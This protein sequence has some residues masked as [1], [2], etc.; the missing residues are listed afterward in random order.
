[1]RMFWVRTLRQ[2]GSDVRSPSLSVFRAPCVDYARGDGESIGPSQARS[3]RPM[4]L[5]P[6]PLWVGQYGGL[7][8][9]Y[10]RDPAAGENAPAGPMYSRDGS[11]RRA[12][13]DPIGWA[14]LHKVPTP[15]AQL[16]VLQRRILALQARD[17]ELGADI[18][19]RD[20]ELQ[21]LGVELAALRECPHLA[22]RPAALQRRL[23]AL[24]A[25][26]AALRAERAETD[27]VVGALAAR[28]ARL[29]DSSVESGVP[30][31]ERRAHL[32]RWA[33]PADSTDI[34]LGA[35]LEVWGAISISLVI[36]CVVGLIVGARE[37]L[38]LGLLA[39]L[40]TVLV[41]E[42]VFHRHLTRLVTGV[43]VALAVVSVLVLM[44][45][46]FWQIVV[47]AVLAAGLYL[48]WDNL[49][50]LRG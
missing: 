18:A 39:L 16:A 9:L 42:A 28:Y 19:K 22:P 3:W 38:W 1:M 6:L 48:L 29:S 4:L 12:W 5:D 31:D 23:E 33:Q 43:T 30:A 34:R 27:G 44:Y 36:I 50:E 7:W 45:T 11:V 24:Q 26:T 14:G 10:A 49:S 47:A 20:E 17:A 25:Q 41:V 8:G 13:Y 21:D 40:A 15:P 32:Q 2:A 46:F 35:W 37:H